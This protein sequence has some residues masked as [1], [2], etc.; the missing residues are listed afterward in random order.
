MGI[1]GKGT[2]QLQHAGHHLLPTLPACCMH[3]CEGEA[4]V[5]SL[6]CGDRSVPQKESNRNQLS[7]QPGL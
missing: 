3:G 6:A 7:L 5:P 2:W 4:E 1:F